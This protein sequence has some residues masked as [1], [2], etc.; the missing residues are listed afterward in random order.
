MQSRDITFFEKTGIAAIII[1]SPKHKTMDGV[2]ARC[3]NGALAIAAIGL[4]T[5]KIVRI[6]PITMPICWF[7]TE[8]WTVEK[9]KIE[10]VALQIPYPS[11]ANTTPTTPKIPLCNKL[12]KPINNIMKPCRNKKYGKLFAVKIFVSECL[13]LTRN[14]P[15]IEPTVNARSTALY[16]YLNS[17]KISIDSLGIRSQTV[18]KQKL[19]TKAIGTMTAINVLERIILIP[20]KKL[21]V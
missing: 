4:A 2:A 17:E 21:L 20:S 11:Q 10:P 5:E 3:D 13:A 7:G 6:A 14:A 8:S 9:Y 16:I 12:K 15:R 19:V 18:Q 1:T